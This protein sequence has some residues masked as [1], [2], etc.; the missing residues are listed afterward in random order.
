MKALANIQG[1]DSPR[2]ML[3][4]EK[5]HEIRR[6]NG[7]GTDADLARYIGIDPASLY[8]YATGKGGPSNRVLA[9]LKAAFPLVPLGD[10]VKLEGGSL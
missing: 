3:N 6:A 1:N 5:L 4:M 8:R 9:R 10:F 7:I 2:L